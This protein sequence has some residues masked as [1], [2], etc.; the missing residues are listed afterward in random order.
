MLTILHLLSRVVWKIEIRLESASEH[1]VTAALEATEANTEDAG[2]AIWEN[3]T[4]SRT[5]LDLR[6]N[7]QQP[8]VVTT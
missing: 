3:I 8:N 1:L 5:A 6:F 7:T 2:D 4:I